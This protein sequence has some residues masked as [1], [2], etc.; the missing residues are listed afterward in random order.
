M[1]LGNVLRLRRFHR[2][3]KLLVFL[4]LTCSISYFVFTFSKHSDSRSAVDE[5]QHKARVGKNVVDFE[6]VSLAGLNVRIWRALCGSNVANLR[7]SLFFP[8]YPDEEKIITESFQVEDNTEDYGQVFLGFLHPAKSG[9]YRFA[10]ASD[11][12]S[13]LWLSPSE[14]P[15]KKSMIARVFT[16]ESAAWTQKNE[17]HKYPDQIS[18]DVTLRAGK[19]YYI[20]VVHKQ[21]SGDGFVQVFW[22]RSGDADFKLISSEYLSTYS[23]KS[24][25]TARQESAHA[26]LSER[27]HHEYKL[28]GD[29]T[30]G[31]YLKFY[32]LPL[33][34]KNNYLPQC[35]YKTSFVLSGNVYR[36]EGLK[37]V[38]ESN[39]FPADDTSMGHPGIV[40][41]WRNRA[42]DKEVIQ[43]IVDKMISS[44]R[45]NISR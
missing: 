33:I 7:R 24:A 21:G 39:V 30:S 1:A 26:V 45:E 16:A 41:T 18:K 12:S 19:R 11:D 34:A 15:E 10:I 8:R 31:D 5:L 22:K 35:D 43:S 32:S 13:E 6:P 14:D 27:Y 3:G 44:L 28:K 42:A 23:N 40:W 37:M 36:Y 4:L 29:K 9:S 25:V 17:L 38:A 2:F 20:E